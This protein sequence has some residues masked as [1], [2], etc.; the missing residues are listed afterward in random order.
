MGLMFVVK[1]YGCMGRS[2]P[3][4]ND[5][6]YLYIHR[7]WGYEYWAKRSHDGSYSNRKLS[8]LTLDA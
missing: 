2:V 5:T 6:H 4:R 7:A 3:A 8:N 1:T